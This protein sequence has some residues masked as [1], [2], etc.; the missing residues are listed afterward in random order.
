M[1]SDRIVQVGRFCC[2]YDARGVS[3]D[4]L[5]SPYRHFRYPCTDSP[6]GHQFLLQH[7]D[8][9]REMV[10][11]EEGIPEW[12]AAYEVKKHATSK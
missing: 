12:L 9:F 3:I 6:T 2:K 1:K 10:K 8:L 4:E 11:T 5:F 7:T